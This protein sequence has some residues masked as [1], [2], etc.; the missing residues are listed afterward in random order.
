M[1]PTQ[2]VCCSIRDGLSVNDGLTRVS[3][4]IWSGDI[5]IINNMITIEPLLCQRDSFVRVDVAIVLSK[6]QHKA[7]ISESD[8]NKE[9]QNKSILLGKVNHSWRGR[10]A[11]NELTS[12]LRNYYVLA[13]KICFM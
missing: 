7:D 10:L 11:D 6:W 5:L 9:I 8:N 12:T 2:L 13:S 1:V 4:R 3:V